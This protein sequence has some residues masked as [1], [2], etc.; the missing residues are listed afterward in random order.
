MS[1]LQ[2]EFSLRNF[3]SRSWL[4]ALSQDSAQVEEWL[5]VK[6]WI[7]GMRVIMPGDA[8]VVEIPRAAK[9]A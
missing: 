7:K 6:C 3:L 8:L 1:S 4:D 2:T 9:K 5:R